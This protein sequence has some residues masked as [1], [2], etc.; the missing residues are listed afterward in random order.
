[1][2]GRLPKQMETALEL[3]EGCLSGELRVEIY[4]GTRAVIDGECRVQGYEEDCLLL[5]TPSRAVRIRGRQLRITSFEKRC[6][7]V[8]GRLTSVEFE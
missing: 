3:P 5:Q 8:V 2:H 6:V 4:A 7:V 1:M